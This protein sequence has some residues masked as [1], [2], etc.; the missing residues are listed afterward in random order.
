[1]LHDRFTAK[2]GWVKHRNYLNFAILVLLLNLMKYYKLIKH[3]CIK[4]KDDSNGRGLK[5]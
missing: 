2:L 5:Q 3:K 1:M 4:Q